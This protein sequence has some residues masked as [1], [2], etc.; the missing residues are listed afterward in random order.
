MCVLLETKLSSQPGMM[1][2]AVFRIFD[3][4]SP[5]RHVQCSRYVDRLFQGYL[6]SPS[7]DLNLFL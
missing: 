5:F 2:G 4:G 6:S 1:K 3:L 7:K